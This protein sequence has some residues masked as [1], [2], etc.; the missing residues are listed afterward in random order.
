MNRLVKYSILYLVFTASTIIAH[1]HDKDSVVIME[2]EEDL[3]SLLENSQGPS[4]ISFHMDRCGWCIQMQ[5]I[6]QE[7]ADNDEFG[8]I[9]FYRVN[10][11]TL[12]AST[13]VKEALNEKIPGYP[14][15]LF[16]NQGKVVDKQVG[17]TTKEVI[18]QKLNGL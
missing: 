4:A 2:T 7:L 8:H 16:M 14:T 10:G 3:R 17:G 9:T 6:F 1:V 18:I 13:H 12:K 5:P 11:P 15:I